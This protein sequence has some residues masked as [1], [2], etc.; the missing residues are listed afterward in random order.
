M[1]PCGSNCSFETEHG[2]AAHRAYERSCSGIRFQSGDDSI[3]LFSGICSVRLAQRQRHTPRNTSASRLETAPRTLLS[4]ID[5]AAIDRQKPH[6][7]FQRRRIHE[8]ATSN[9]V[10]GSDRAWFCRCGKGGERIVLRFS[11]LLCLL[12]RVLEVGS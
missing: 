10:D 12:Q 4:H 5:S 9:S 11:R 3:F 1:L 2:N 6:L 8:K 7:I